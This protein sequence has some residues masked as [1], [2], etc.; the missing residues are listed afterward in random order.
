[1]GEERLQPP[2]PS[3]GYATVANVVIA[4]EAHQTRQDWLKLL[5]FHLDNC[6]FNAY[7]GKAIFVTKN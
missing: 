6:I 3:P 7:Y 5:R 4:Q 2:A 1:M